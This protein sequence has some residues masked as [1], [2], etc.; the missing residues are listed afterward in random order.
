MI[1]WEHVKHFSSEEFD[2]PYFPGSGKFIDGVLLLKLEQLREWTG[3]PI[4]THWAVGG[5]IDVE[6]KHGHSKNSYHLKK[7]ACD[8]HLE[9]DDNPRCQYYQVAKASFGGIG[10]Y[11]NE[12]KWHDELLPIAFHVDVRPKTKTQVWRRKDGEY[13]YLL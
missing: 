13:L 4:I 9:T 7:M 3:W 2:D 12:W 5:C 10:V 1:H 6:G 11:Q 8:F